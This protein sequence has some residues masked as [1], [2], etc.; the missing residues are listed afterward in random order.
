VTLLDLIATAPELTFLAGAQTAHIS[1]NT[2]QAALHRRLAP[3]TPAGHFASA[4][5]AVI[6]GT[7]AFRGSTG[8]Q[9]LRPVLEN[10][11]RADP[12]AQQQRAELTRRLLEKLR[13]YP[14][15][16][17]FPLILIDCRTCKRLHHLDVPCRAD[18]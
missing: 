17:S 13:D 3:E 5:G 7:E 8:I 4:F 1:L 6:G 12:T 16:P 18:A 11:H 14:R 15:P 2:L 10:P 9:Q